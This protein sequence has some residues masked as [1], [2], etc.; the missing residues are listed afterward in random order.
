MHFTKRT[1]RIILGFFTLGL[2]LVLFITISSR[3]LSSAKE[4]KRYEEER[5]AMRPPEPNIAEVQEKSMSQ[6]RRFAAQLQPWMS[7]QVPAEVSGRVVEVLVEAGE[8]VKKGQPLVKLDEQLTRIAYQSA[9]AKYDEEQRLLGEAQRLVKSRAISETALRA[10]EAAAR[11]AEAVLAESHQMF[12]RHTVLSPFD[13]VVNRRLVDIGDA[14]N[15]NQPV[16]EVVDVS[17]LRVEF[18]VSEN[19]VDAFPIGKKLQLQLPSKPA[20]IYGP[21]VDFASRSADED[22]RLY[23][24]EAVL[25]NPGGELPGGLQGIIQTEVKRFA[26]SPFVPAAAVRF[27]GRKSLVLRA[28]EDGGFQQTEI[29]VGP[30]IDGFYPVFSGLA[31]GDRV[32]IR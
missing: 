3:V 4:Q 18:H 32:L 29:T 5:A 6:L 21:S 11:I 28:G 12:S 27:S 10:Q 13:G 7:A 15:Q 26:N 20:E 19:D 1:K 25:E 16:V 8:T 17:R 31:P 23:R 24:M 14:V 2:F 30:E 22:T 9:K